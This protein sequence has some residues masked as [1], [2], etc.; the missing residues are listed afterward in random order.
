MK[1]KIV[2]TTEK[3]EVWIVRW[4]SSD[5]AQQDES[6]D[7]LAP[8]SAEYSETDILPDEREYRSNKG[9]QK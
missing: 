1:K 8:V 4:P 5:R 9:E 2:I 6:E 7:S 3:R